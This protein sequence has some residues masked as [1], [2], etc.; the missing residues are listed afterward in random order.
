MNINFWALFAIFFPAVTGFTQG[1]SMS[2]DLKDPG[3]SLPRGT[4]SAVGLSI[5][6]YF[7]SAVL[8]AA[9][10]PAKT[11]TGDY[12]AMRQVAYLE[13]LVIAGVIAATLSSAM[14]SF[15]G[16]PVIEFFRF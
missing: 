3:K 13:F 5:A 7:L 15:L 6:V 11:L 2:G 8:L 1:V 16:A 4:F 10:L 12:S 9:S 14:A